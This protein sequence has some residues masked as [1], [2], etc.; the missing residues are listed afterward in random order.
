MEKRVLDLIKKNYS[1]FTESQKKIGSFVAEN[2]IK[3][4]YMTAQNLAAEVDVSDATIIRF[5][6][7]IGFSGYSEMRDSLRREISIYD[8]PHERLIRNYE[9]DENIDSLFHQ[10]G[11]NDFFAHEN[12]YKN[13]NYTLIDKVADEIHKADTIHVIGF[14]TDKII[15]IFLDWYLWLMGFNTICYTENGFGFSNSFSVVKAN[16]LVIMGVSPRHLKD[17]KIALELAKEKGATIVSLTTQRMS[18]IIMISDINLTVETKS[19]EFLNS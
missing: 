5:S 4:I 15:A 7:S 9:F 1:S 17:E 11:K 13:I 14:G 12:F 10:V 19:N 18:D 16:D 2:Y 8:S 3:V 6:K